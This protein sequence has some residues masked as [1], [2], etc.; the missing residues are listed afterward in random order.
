MRRRQ[1]LAINLCCVGVM[2][3]VTPFDVSAELSH[4]NL[5]ILH[6]AAAQHVSRIHRQLPR[7]RDG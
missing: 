3:E 6:G 1:R 7:A 4:Y 2:Y 5:L